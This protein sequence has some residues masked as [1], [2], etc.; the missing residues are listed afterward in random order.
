MATDPSQH[1]PFLDFFLV[2]PSLSLPL[3]DD[4]APSFFSFLSFFLPP[5]SAMLA[6][7]RSMFAPAAYQ[8]SAGRS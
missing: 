1:L 6:L 3:D 2:P 8:G 7:Y 5:S 4:E